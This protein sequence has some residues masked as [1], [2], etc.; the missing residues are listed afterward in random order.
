MMID[1]V[2]YPLSKTIELLSSPGVSVTSLPPVPTQSVE[3][4]HPLCDLVMRSGRDQ[5]S[6][7]EGRD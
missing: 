3:Q 6:G 5:E 7:V 4:P 2:A 1:G